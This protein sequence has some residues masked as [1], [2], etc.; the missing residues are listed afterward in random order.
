MAPRPPH[1]PTPPKAPVWVHTKRTESSERTYERGQRALDER[2]WDEALEAFT[3]VAA[4][5]GS[6]KEG[7]HYW[8]AYTLNKLGRRE[9]AQA[10]IAELRRAFPSSRWLDD[11]KVL[12]AE[13][14]QSAGQ[15]ARPEAE[16]DDELKLLALN[17]IIQSDHS[18][19][20]S[21]SSRGA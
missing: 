9:D 4:K 19:H 17:G 12:E 5:D 16:S 1:P 11:A 20:F 3:Q 13:M 18:A 6:R 10:A 15:P 7:A 2:R 21:I 8:K 14:R